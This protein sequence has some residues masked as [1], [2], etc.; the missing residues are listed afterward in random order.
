MRLLKTKLNNQYALDGDK[1]ASLLSKDIW[2]AEELGITPSAT[3]SLYR[4]NFS[5]VKPEWLKNSVKLFVKLQ[6]ATKSMETC[7]SYITGLM[8]FGNFI[9]QHDESLS[10]IGI[11]REV[12]IAYID[13]LH[14]TQLSATTRGICLIH[15]RT[16]IEISSCEKW[17]K[18]KYTNI[19]FE[20][21]IPRPNIH[22]P[23]FI[24]ETVIKQLNTHLK[25]LPAHTQRLIKVLLETGRRIGEVCTLPYD[26]LYQDESSDTYLIVKETKT[27]KRYYIPISKTCIEIIKEQQAYIKNIGK[28]NKGYLFPGSDRGK[29]PHAKSRNINS[30][31]NKLALAKNIID[32]N[33]TV[34]HFS[35]HQFR[36]TVGTRMINAGVPQ[37]VVQR[38]LG[39]ESPEMTSRYAYIHDQTLKQEFKKLQGK[40]VNIQGESITL[41]QVAMDDAQW[42]KHN[43][44]SQAL[45][46][47]LCTL[48]CAQQRCPH[49]N[50]CL[51]CSNFKTSKQYL[52]QHKSQL[53]QTEEIIERA[54]VNGWER[55]VQMNVD[56]QT[57][58]R[59]IINALEADNNE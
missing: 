29:V 50:A 6:S 14:H 40:L 26:C 49:A 24:P 18:F 56:V 47:G 37:H 19:I 1:Q 23:R 39:H 51:T 10:P 27:N 21:D 38:Y 8:H 59:R 25:S 20:R 55:Q 13:Y 54:K 28:Q 4:L 57:N 35:S 7:R 30:M 22:A 5:K 9:I 45:P 16:F 32:D 48:P 34:W 41:D 17:L 44:M 53:A 46:N 43:M 52:S 33:G 42:L 11:T 58:L 31:L 36:H 15:L 12:I 3:H 2:L